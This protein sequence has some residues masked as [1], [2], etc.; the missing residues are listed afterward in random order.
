LAAGIAAALAS[1]ELV[2]ADIASREQ[3]VELGKTAATE[4]EPSELA[5]ELAYTT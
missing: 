1:T 3:L 2:A 5:I 4:Q